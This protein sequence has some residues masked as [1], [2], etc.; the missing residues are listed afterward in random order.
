MQTQRFCL[1]SN[2]GILGLGRTGFAIWAIINDAFVA[3]GG[4]F[5]QVGR[6][7][8]AC[9]AKGGVVAS[10]GNAHLILVLKQ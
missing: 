9:S 7:D 2:I 10:N 3:L 6:L 4:N 1:R 8:L 5:N